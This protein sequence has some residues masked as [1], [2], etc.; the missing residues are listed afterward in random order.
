MHL[1]EE[2]VQRFLHGELEATSEV[3]IKR[4]IAECGKCRSMIEE[5]RREEEETFLRLRAVDHDVP[6]LSADS[7]I[8]GIDPVRPGRF[9]RAAII[10]FG[11]GVAG[12]AWAAPG[13]PVPDWIGGLLGRG[14]DSAPPAPVTAPPVPAA[15][16]SAGI[17]VL[18]GT[19]LSIRIPRPPR[20]GRVIFF[21]ANTGAV[22]VR[23][24]MGAAA[25]TSDEERIVIDVRADSLDIF[26]A[27]PSGA[28]LVELFIGGRSV[29]RKD[30][31]GVVA[32]VPDEDRRWV[33]P[34]GQ[35]TPVP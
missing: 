7:L 22:R 11:L 35:S 27:V 20:A 26:I 24:R 29:L 25:F 34:L 4:H 12:T 5:S 31:P 18:P 13:S 15:T 33:F 16:D 6:L 3:F 17:D 2:R 8:A 32:S 19:A 1:D 10:V 14:G 21:I 23:T 9:R 30:G 28:P